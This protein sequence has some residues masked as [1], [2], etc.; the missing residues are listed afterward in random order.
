MEADKRMGSFITESIKFIL[1]TI[2]S[3]KNRSSCSLEGNPR[4]DQTKPLFIRQR[5]KQSH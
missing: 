2:H 5:I 4:T 1:E 3:T